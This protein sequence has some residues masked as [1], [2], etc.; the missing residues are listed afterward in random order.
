M[1]VTVIQLSLLGACAS[2]GESWVVILLEGA[3]VV[4]LKRQ[5]NTVLHLCVCIRAAGTSAKRKCVCV[6]L[7]V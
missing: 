6:C 3:E 7:C 4:L 2:G 1:Y 5:C